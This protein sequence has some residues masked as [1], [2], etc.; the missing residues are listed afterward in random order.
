MAARDSAGKRYVQLRYPLD[1]FAPNVRVT[2]DDQRVGRGRISD[3]PAQV[4]RVVDEDRRA[5]RIAI[6][7]LQQRDGFADFEGRSDDEKSHTYGFGQKYER[8][9][10]RLLIPRTRGPCAHD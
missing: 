2:C 9:T 3:K 5:G 4:C 8:G 7:H 6:H 1:Q 10:M